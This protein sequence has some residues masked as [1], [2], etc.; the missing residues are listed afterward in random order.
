MCHIGT[1]IFNID[2]QLNIIVKT[3][4]GN[5]IDMIRDK[6]SFHFFLIF[7]HHML[8]AHV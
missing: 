2:G 5:T 6:H 3:Q 8:L 1:V 7:Q 4:E